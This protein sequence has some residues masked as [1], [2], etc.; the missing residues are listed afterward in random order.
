MKRRGRIQVVLA[1][2]ATL[3]FI[4]P[5]HYLLA[6]DASGLAT[7]GQ[8]HT[9]ALDVQLSPSGE[10]VGQVLNPAGHPVEKM[11]LQLVHR[12]RTVATASS[13][14]NGAF[15][16]S[17]VRGGSHQIVTHGG[18]V[19]VR[20]WKNQTA[21]PAAHDGILLVSDGKTVRGQHP[22]SHLFTN[23]AVI[24]LAI[25]MAIAIPI[26][27]NNSDSGTASP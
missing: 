18:A 8:S 13:D 21:P 12:G 3:S 7:S 6:A 22:I 16:F 9:T 26:I 20:C 11:S 17:N 5:P 27:I 1:F 25:A 10:L 4:L 24:G 19:P 23:P 14:R 2:A 15:R